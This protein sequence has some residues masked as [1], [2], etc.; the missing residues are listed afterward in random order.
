MSIN[1]INNYRINPDLQTTY[2]LRPRN[3]KSPR[4]PRFTCT[5]CNADGITDPHTHLDTCAPKEDDDD[6]SVEEDVVIGNDWFAN[7]APPGIASDNDSDESVTLD[8]EIGKQMHHQNKEHLEA[9][10]AHVEDTKGEVR[11][12]GWLNDNRI[13]RREVS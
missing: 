8:F 7:A 9:F 12:L 2:F 4:L 13:T 6:S 5:A 1:C 3:Q 11:L 10:Q